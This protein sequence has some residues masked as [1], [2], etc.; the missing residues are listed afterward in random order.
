MIQGSCYVLTYILEALVSS[1]VITALSDIPA[2]AVLKKCG[3]ALVI[4]L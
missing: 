3:W 4:H 2:M 1:V